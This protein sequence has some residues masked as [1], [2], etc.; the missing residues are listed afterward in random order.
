[1]DD[2]FNHR[3]DPS[4]FTVEVSGVNRKYPVA[5]L[6]DLDPSTATVLQPGKGDSTYI[7]IRFKKPT[8]LDGMMLLNGYTK[9]AD[10]WRNNSRI[11]SLLAYKTSY[12]V[13]GSIDD[14]RIDTTLHENELEV[15]MTGIEPPGYSW[16]PLIDNADT[17]CLS[18]L[19]WDEYY[20]ELRIVIT[21]TKKGLKYDD[22]CVSEII[23]IGK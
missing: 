8:R 2:I 3:I 10:T 14:G 4:Q 7:T 13:I 22:L 18:D 15:E 9:N 19:W 21:S 17:F 11:D 16:Q 1:M 20:T 23:F 12:V 5:N 6:F